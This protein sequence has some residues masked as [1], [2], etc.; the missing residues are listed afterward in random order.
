MVFRNICPA[1]RHARDDPDIAIDH[2]HELP[3]VRISV[4][5]WMCPFIKQPTLLQRHQHPLKTEAIAGLQLRVLLQAPLNGHIHLCSIYSIHIALAI[6]PPSP[7]CGEQATLKHC[8][9]IPPRSIPTPADLPDKS[10][11]PTEGDGDGRSAAIEA[12]RQALKRIVAMLVE[13]TICR[14]LAEPTHPTRTQHQKNNT[15]TP[16]N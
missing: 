8:Q 13:R 11:R 15:T 3:L 6:D 9:Q 10:P 2:A 1:I 4:G 7:S 5:I 12:N 16:K 14:I